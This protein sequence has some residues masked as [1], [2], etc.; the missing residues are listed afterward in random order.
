MWMNDQHSEPIASP[1]LIQVYRFKKNSK[2]N[3]NT[4]LVSAR[5]SCFVFRAWLSWFHL[6]K[7]FG[8]MRGQNDRLLRS[9][10]DHDE[11]YYLSFGHPIPLPKGCQLWM[12]SALTTSL[13]LF[14]R[15]RRMI[16]NVFSIRFFLRES[17][18][19]PWSLSIEKSPLPHVL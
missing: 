8:L 7:L 6:K 11:L 9:R 10:L 12:H 17:N 15:L 4:H 5:V 18:Y 16:S 2:E 1:F 3:R 19:F 13:F 14:W